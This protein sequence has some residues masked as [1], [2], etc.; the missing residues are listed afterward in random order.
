M[1]DRFRYNTRLFEFI[2]ESNRIEGIH[3]NP[4]PEEIQAHLRFLRQ[5]VSVDSLRDFVAAV[6]PG[7][8]L[9]N[10]EGMNVVVA[11][12]YP[13]FGGPQI[14]TYL[15]QLL[16]SE[17]KPNTAYRRHIQYEDIHP[18]TDGNG[19]SGR[20]LWLHDMGGIE[21]V[22]LGFL[23]TFYYQTLSQGDGLGNGRTKRITNMDAD[24][25][26]VGKLHP[27]TY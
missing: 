10:R 26:M 20:V 9:R 6:Q 13:P 4:T 11:Q 5:P 25:E 24:H 22:S 15:K 3:R 7:A 16:A 21:R 18:F 1:K 17:A 8:E 2:K 12:Y 19:R 23:H 27:M 14:E